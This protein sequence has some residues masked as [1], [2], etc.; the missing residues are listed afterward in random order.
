MPNIIIVGD[1]RYEIDSDYIAGA[2][3]ERVGLKTLFK[4]N[5]TAQWKVG[6]RNERGRQHL[7]FDTDI[8]TEPD[9]GRVFPE[10]H[11]YG[12]TEQVQTLRYGGSQWVMSEGNY[13]RD[14]LI[15][16]GAYHAFGQI[17]EER[18]SHMSPGEMRKA[19]AERGIWIS[20][21]HCVTI[22][23]LKFL[24]ARMAEAVLTSEDIDRIES[25]K[26]PQRRILEIC[27]DLK[28]KDW[29][30]NPTSDTVSW[31]A[32][33][34]A[35]WSTATV[36]KMQRDG[37]AG[38]DELIHATGNGWIEITQKGVLAVRHLRARDAELGHEGLAPPKAM[39]RSRMW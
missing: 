10:D 35:G 14:L 9:S 38:R 3:H 7:R 26:E 5:G 15:A 22:G 24:E 20:T 31:M 28:D 11:E 23:H 17:V 1:S 19:L 2:L 12:A 16:S 18:G 21:D 34:S 36:L 13:R 32:K 30:R 27:C 4:D 25:L 8:V 33:R 37:L 29:S 6:G 39:P